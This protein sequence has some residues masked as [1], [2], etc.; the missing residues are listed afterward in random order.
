MEGTA[1]DLPGDPVIL[2]VVA[3][4]APKGSVFPVEED[5][6]HRPGGQWA[7]TQPVS[8]FAQLF[9]DPIWNL[10]VQLQPARAGGMIAERAVHLVADDIGGFASLLDI[11][12]EFDH[13]Q[14]K[15][16]AV[17]ILGIATLDGKRQVRFA[18]LEGYAGR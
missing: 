3:G 8:H 2:A 4:S 9:S 15:L 1:H 6:V 5:S 10:F 18:I 7:E 12:P 16:E 11:H 14:E 17:L 13:V